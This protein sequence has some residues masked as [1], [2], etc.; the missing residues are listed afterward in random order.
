MA[1]HEPET[2]RID[3]YEQNTIDFVAS[4]SDRKLRNFE[5][6]SDRE[7]CKNPRLSDA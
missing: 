2:A 4:G 7:P 3:A 6:P 5:T 1:N